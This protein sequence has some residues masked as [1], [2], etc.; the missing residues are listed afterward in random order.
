MRTTT[1]TGAVEMAR[2]QPFPGRCIMHQARSGTWF[3]CGIVGENRWGESATLVIDLTPCLLR[4]IRSEACGFFST[5]S[6]NRHSRQP[7]PVRELAPGTPWGRKQRA[8]YAGS[9]ALGTRSPSRRT[10]THPERLSDLP[11]HRYSGARETEYWQ[12]LPFI[13]C[14]ENRTYSASAGIREYACSRR[15][16]PGWPAHSR[17]RPASLGNP[18]CV[19]R[20]CGADP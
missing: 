20:F 5:R 9:V 14:P 13:T 1:P 3:C 7:L 16:P 10:Q 12:I 8:H 6:G 4:W 18:C 19:A 15:A 2:I 11:R 17:H